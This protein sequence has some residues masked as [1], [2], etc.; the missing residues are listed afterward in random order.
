MAEENTERE[1][2]LLSPALMCATPGSIMDR[3]SKPTSA[4]SS[5]A[6]QL[7]QT[8]HRKALKPTRQDPQLPRR[9]GKMAQRKK[10]SPT[11]T[12]KHATPGSAAS[13]KSRCCTE[14][15]T[16]TTPHQLPQQPYSTWRK[17]GRKT[18]LNYDKIGLSKTGGGGA[19]ADLPCG[20]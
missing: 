11:P 17:P 2:K 19:R 1:K 16:S 8:D 13:D 15:P 20:Y 12:P 3:S 18:T 10:R 9:A 14:T 5:H 6:I 4:S 7:R